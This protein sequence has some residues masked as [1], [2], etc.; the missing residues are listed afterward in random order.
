MRVLLVY[1]LRDVLNRRHPLPTLADIHI[2]LSYISSALKARGHETRLAV[3]DSESPSRSLAILDALVSRFAPELV[4]FTAVSTQFPFI[5]SAAR[6]LKERRPDLTTL[7]GGVHASLQPEAAIRGAFDAVC[8]GEGELPACELADQKSRGQ[9][10]SGIANLW[11]KR[12]DGTLERNAPREFVRDLDALPMPDRDLWHEWVWTRRHVCQVVLPS[13]GCPFNC[14]YCC[15]H[16]LRKLAPGK[17][18][19]LRLPEA[20]VREIRAVKAR[21]PETRRIYLQS[22][23]IAVDAG[24][25]HELALGIKEFNDEL[26]LKIEYACNFR[27]GRSLLKA[28]V[29]DALALANVRTLEIGLESGSERVRREILRRHYSNEDF[30][31]AV[32]LAR[33]RGM[34]VNVYNM[35]GI[36]GETL[37]DHQQT[38]QVNHQV[39][40]DRTLTSIFFPYPGTDLAA[41]CEAQG[42]IREAGSQTAERSRATL[43]LPSFSRRDIQKA[44][45]W[46][47]YHVYRGLRPWHFR[48]RK[49][50][51]NKAFAHPRA[52]AAFMRLLPLWHALRHRH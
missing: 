50:L 16:A 4:G 38:I 5:D 36:P 47:E 51:R 6:H 30:S 48:L 23:T 9:F 20:V 12:G 34:E 49:V 17:Y 3:L 44:F 18:V 31:R 43:D 35:I 21:Y 1:S 26:P 22:E 11:I 19:R 8:I 28:Q 33:E 2:G 46:F 52:H 32:R 29:F 15:N 45:E 10:P 39:C 41:L 14:S 13:R 24:W 25:L 7:L 42:L 37:Q 27:V 40:P